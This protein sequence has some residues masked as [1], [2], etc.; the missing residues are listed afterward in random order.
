MEHLNSL[1]VPILEGP[2]ARMGA[3]GPIRSV[4]VRDPD[5]NLDEIAVPERPGNDPLSLAV[6]DFG[7]G[8]A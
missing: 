2:V 6:T 1:G 4:Y 3:V 8:K 7:V 5:G